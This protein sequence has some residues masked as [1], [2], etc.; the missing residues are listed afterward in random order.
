MSAG[1]GA[2]S[3][4]AVGV[5]SNAS[6]LTAAAAEQYYPII[7]EG[8]KA[9]RTAVPSGS[10]VGDS[11]RQAVAMGVSVCEGSFQMEVEGSVSGHAIWLWNG[12]DG[13]SVDELAAGEAYVQNA[14]SGSVSPGGTLANGA[15]KHAVSVVLNRTN[16]GQKIIMPG[17]PVSNANTTTT[18]NNTIGLTW[19]APSDIPAGYTIAGYVIWRSL[20]GGS[21]VYFLKYQSGTTT[22][23]SD[24]GSIALPN[25]SVTP[26]A[27]SLYQHEMV[28]SPPVSGD[29]LT[30]F[31][32]IVN[33]NND[34]AQQFITCRMDSMK[35]SVSGLDDKLMADFSLKGAAAAKIAN[36]TP[37][38]VP[39]EPMLGWHCIIQMNGVPDQTLE[40]FE[41]DCSN[42]VQVVPGMRGVAFNRDTISGARQINGQMTRQFQDV[43]LWM[44]MLAGLDFSLKFTSYGQCVANPVT[45]GITST[46]ANSGI[47]ALPFQMYLIIELPRCKIS[48][49]GGNVGG[50]DRIIETVAFEAFK[51]QTTGTDMKITMI[52][53]VEVYE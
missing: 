43:S 14:P 15:Y 17:S 5:E 9:D 25:Q 27:A 46:M 51:D 47:D 39:L 12:N 11:M 29:R 20:V 53:T 24:T 44:Q 45:H 4:F 18:G 52:N 1:L 38:F 37:T 41:I 16:D 8:L 19:S 3:S 23:F 49:A 32:C 36:F 40:S 31:T 42:G 21:T 30:P 28:G 26:Y 2:L 35:L 22:S 10:I 6:P 50:P 13:Y 33:H 48:K 7:S 34:Y